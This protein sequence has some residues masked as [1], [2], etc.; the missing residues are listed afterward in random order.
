LHTE[1]I[2]CGALKADFDLLITRGQTK[3]N[4]L[5]IL[6]LRPFSPFFIRRV[7]NI[8]SCIGLMWQGFGSSGAAGVAP[9]RRD[10]GL[11]P[12][13][14]QSLPAGSE[15]DPLLAKAEPISDAGDAF[16]MTC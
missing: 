9:V 7:P 5:I 10:Q 11:P 2:Y 15:T 14:T 4:L 6:I 16:V 8:F 13:W 1:T 3:G 12:C